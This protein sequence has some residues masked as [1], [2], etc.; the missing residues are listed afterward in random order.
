MKENGSF[1]GSLLLTQALEAGAAHTS[2]VPTVGLDPSSLPEEFGFD[3]L[4]GAQAMGGEKLSLTG[5][6]RAGN[7]T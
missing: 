5:L 1:E 3:G 6:D 2:S 7:R 4:A